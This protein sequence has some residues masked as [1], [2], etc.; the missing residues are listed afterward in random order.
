[1][2]YKSSVI[3]KVTNNDSN[4]NNTKDV[5]IVVPLKYLRNLWRTLDMPLINCE[6]NLI[7]TWSENYILTD[8]TQAAIPAQGD[9]P[10]RPAI[11]AA[12]YAIFKITGTKLYVPVVTLSFQNDNKLF[13]Q[14]KTK[15][16]ETIQWK[17]YRPEKSN[18][19]K[20]KLN[21]LIDPTFIKANKLFDLS[22]EN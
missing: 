9:N 17:K 1:M 5:E 15:F 8:I 2:K 12:T 22:L 3:E 10:E 7:L 6:I 13:R 4:G 11:N 14:L 16:K 20:N 19:T 18:Q 21:Y